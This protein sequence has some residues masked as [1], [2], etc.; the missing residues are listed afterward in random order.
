MENQGIDKPIR[1]GIWA[2][3]AADIEYLSNK[4]SGFFNNKFFPGCGDH[5]YKE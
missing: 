1:E 5:L 2:C 4:V 3:E